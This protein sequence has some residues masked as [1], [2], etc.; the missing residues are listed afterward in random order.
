MGF[1][2]SHQPS[3]MIIMPMADDQRVHRGDI[4][5][6]QAEIVG[7]DLRREAEIM[8]ETPRLPALAGLQMQSEA[9]FAFQRLALCD[10]RKP[11]TRYSQARRRQ[12]LKGYVMC[13]VGDLPDDDLIDDG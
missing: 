12:G 8:Q 10:T 6:Q 7:I 13:I 3:D 1:Q 4:D 2:E 11:R 5:V 9:P